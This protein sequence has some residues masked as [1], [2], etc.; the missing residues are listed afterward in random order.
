MDVIQDLR[1]KLQK[2]ITR[3]LRAD[4][5]G[6]TPEIIRFWDYFDGNSTLASI[7]KELVQQFPA[8]AAE[9][10][11]MSS[12]STIYGAT[13]TETAAIGCEILRR[14]AKVDGRGFSF[15]NYTKFKGSLNE[16]LDD[17]RTAYLEPFY[18]WVDEHLQDKSLVLG[19]LI[20][21]KHLAEWFR[22]DQLWATYSSESR[23]GE[24]R[25]ALK[26]YEY[27]YE[28]GISFSIEPTSASGEADM[29][30]IQDKKNPL[31][32]DVKV[33]DPSGGRGPSYIAKGFH[34]VHRYSRTSI[35][36]SATWWFSRSWTGI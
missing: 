19:Y 20:R 8:I 21:F 16:T 13:E 6:F 5:E 35:K 1:Y 24:K 32:A 34:Q 23:F 18:E 4:A 2:R 26:V 11:Q 36:Q 17:C 33:F 30:G 25:L 29:V 9:I 28:Q 12:N 10:D 14:C 7:G 3:V 27:L 22:R 31:I 15:M